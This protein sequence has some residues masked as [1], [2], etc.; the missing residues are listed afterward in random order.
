MH[1]EQGPSVSVGLLT[2]ADSTDLQTLAQRV[3]WNLTADQA[4]LV[5]SV[6]GRIYGYRKE[7]Q[8]IASAALYPFGTALSS[9]GMVIVHRDF[10]HQGLGRR[11][12]QQSLSDAKQTGSRVALVATAD[13]APLYASIGFRVVE[14]VHRVELNSPWHE[15]TENP[16]PR[17]F[18]LGES[19]LPALIELDAS[20]LG[21]KRT[22]LYNTLTRGLHRGVVYRDGK[23]TPCGFALSR[24]SGD[25][26]LI[27]GPL[28]ADDARTAMHLLLDVSAGWT[29]R[30]RVDVPGR[31]SS[32]MAKLLTRGFSETMVS[33]VMLLGA[34]GLPGERSRLFAFV[35]P[36]FG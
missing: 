7:G 30:V 36:V 2:K 16:G 5:L 1:D 18:P 25:D 13:G 11:I 33:P 6:E 4:G 35:D 22:A 27:I 24:T 19:D 32:F 17:A 31:Q 28:V 12:V 10:Q 20:V 23:G 15:P 9:L 8:L 14:K 34:Q 3:G 21:A 26:L 29:G